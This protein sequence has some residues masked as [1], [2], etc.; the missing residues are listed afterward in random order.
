MI[1]ALGKV[2]QVNVLV[3]GAYYSYEMDQTAKKQGSIL[4]PSQLVGKAPIQEKLS[5]SSF[6][7]DEET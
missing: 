2:P 1:D 5:Y 6:E 7:V 4:K 3:G